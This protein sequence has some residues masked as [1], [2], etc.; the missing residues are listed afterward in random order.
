VCGLRSEATQKK[1]LLAEAELTLRKAV[2]IAQSMEMAAVK[3]RQLQSPNNA[4]E[5]SLE[6]GKL[7]VASPCQEGGTNC[8]RCGKHDHRAAQCLLGLLVV[9]AVGREVTLSLYVGTFKPSTQKGKDPSNHSIKTAQ[10]ESDLKDPSEML[11]H[12]GVKKVD[13]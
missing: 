13:R 6:V 11:N 7:F 4:T 12:V 9:I 1:L 3:V 8:Y 2:K 10:V 5:S